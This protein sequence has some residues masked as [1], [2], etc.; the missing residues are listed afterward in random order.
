VAYFLSMA[1]SA[2]LGRRAFR[3]PN[4]MQLVKPAL[5]VSIPTTSAAWTATFFYGGW[6][7]LSTGLLLGICVGTLCAF[8]INLAG[9]RQPVTRWF[10]AM[11]ATPR[12]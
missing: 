1:T 12:L 9:I 11:Q 10:R 4:L 6:T 2:W 3:L 5:I 8:V 7:A